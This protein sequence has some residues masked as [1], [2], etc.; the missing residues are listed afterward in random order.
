MINASTALP[1][2]MRSQGERLGP[3]CGAAMRVRMKDAP[4]KAD[5]HTSCKKYLLCM[6]RGR[7]PGALGRSGAQAV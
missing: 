7:S 4:H 6:V 2:V 5:K 1:M 3:N